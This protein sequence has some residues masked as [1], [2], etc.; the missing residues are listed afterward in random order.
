MRMAL[1][2]ERRDR[3]GGRLRGR[4]LV[5]GRSRRRNRRRSLTSR[6]TERFWKCN[7]KLQERTRKEAKKALSL[8]DEEW[9]RNQGLLEGNNYFG[10]RGQ[11]EA[12]AQLVEVAHEKRAPQAYLRSIATTRE[13][14][15]ERTA[16]YAALYGTRNQHR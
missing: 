6:T 12:L 2:L 8:F 3:Y 14:K 11:A 9:L 4:R 10:C 16:I 1:R 15:F 13:G 5:V 7:R